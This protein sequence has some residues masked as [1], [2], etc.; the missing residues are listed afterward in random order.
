MTLSLQ[1]YR[2]IHFVGIGGIG[3]S[4]LARFML[5]REYMVSGSDQVD[6]EQTRALVDLGARIAI[7]HDA[8]NVGD[9]ELVVVTSAAR[10]DNPE[11]AA[12]RSRGVPV[13][14]RAAVLG[15]IADAGRGIAVAGTHGKTTTSAL[16]GWILTEAGL[17]PTVLVGGIVNTW[18]SNAVVGAGDL[19]VIEADEYDASFLELH[20]DIAVITNVEADHLDFFETEHRMLSA[21]RE[22]ALGVSSTLIICADDPILPELTLDAAAKIISY[23]IQKGDWRARNIVESSDGVSF[24]IRHDLDSSLN[25]G[26]NHWRILLAGEHNIRNALAAIIV[27]HELGVP[28]GALAEAVGTFPGVARRAEVRGEAKDILVVD[29][30]AHHPTEIRVNLAAF[31]QRY[32]RPMRVVFQPHTYSRTKH[33]FDDFV[34]AFD[35]ADVVYLLDIYPAREL[36]DLGIS[37]HMLAEG[38]A[39]RHPDVH[40]TETADATVDR[41]VAESQ[42]GDLVVTMGAGDVYHIGPR[43]L[44]RLSRQ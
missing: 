23:G 39:G 31:R 3:M 42:A 7:G 43:L 13:V 36:D 30:Y 19:V 20:P 8:N 34:S 24:Q 17:S 38:V 22:F 11:T 26:R 2:R 27:C 16:I 1:E 35:D 6:N 18:R 21:F 28:H 33:L 14:K 32:R 40:Y 29:D 37:G 44:D 10:E 4:A 12:A 9:A 15:A 25:M 41:L 5:A